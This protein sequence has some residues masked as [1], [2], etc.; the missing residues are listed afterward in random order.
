MQLC[1][2][3]TNP[4]YLDN[5]DETLKVVGKPG[6]EYI[7]ILD[8]DL[9][10][11]QTTLTKII[12]QYR[13]QPGVPLQNIVERLYF[14]AETCEHLIPSLKDVE[15]AYQVCQEN[16]L[17]FTLVTPYVGP[18]GIEK[19]RELFSFLSDKEDVEVVVNDFGVLHM[20]TSEFKSLIPVLGR[21][22]VKM[23]RDPRF[24]LTGYDIANSS[25]KNKSKVEKNQVDALQNNS[26]DNGL[27]QNLLSEK[28]VSRVGIDYVPQGLNKKSLKSWSLPVDLYW[29]WTYITSGRNCAIAAYTDTSRGY[30]LTE[31]PCAK[32]CQLYE[33]QFESDKKMLKTVQRGNAVWMDAEQE[34]EEFFK[35]G[36]ERLIYMPYIPI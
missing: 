26:L 36:F 2:F 20:L 12:K 5:L 10:V 6:P 30:H 32:Q 11:N 14:G 19:I 16:K 13:L 17:D 15:K 22:L 4:K 9:I 1:V 3:I 8:S 34:F 21:L 25:L 18:K 23:K 24:S 29:P 7:E 28:N 35:M 33:F 27:Y 31:K